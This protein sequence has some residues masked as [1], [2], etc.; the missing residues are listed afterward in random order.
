M[1]QL[2]ILKGYYYYFFFQTLKLVWTHPYALKSASVHRQKRQEAKLS[3]S[4]GSLRDFIDD[5]DEE[6]EDGSGGSSG[7]ATPPPRKK[8]R[9][10]VKAAKESEYC[11]GLYA[12]SFA[13]CVSGNTLI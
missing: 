11:N 10:G 8:T 4:E 6:E 2:S 9:A 5:D 13:S 3:D 1:K 7:S 12:L